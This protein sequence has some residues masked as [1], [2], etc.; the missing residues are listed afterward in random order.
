MERSRQ[1]CR[2]YKLYRFA[3][4]QDPDWTKKPAKELSFGAVGKR[5]LYTRLDP[6]DSFDEITNQRLRR[7]LWRFQPEP[8]PDA[9]EVKKRGR[10]KK[11]N[12]DAAKERENDVQKVTILSDLRKNEL[13]NLLS[14]QTQRS[15]RCS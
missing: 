6:L 1:I 12:D 2:S 3:K 5:W 9:K 8:L 10:P 7:S 13:T 4:E 11:S 15:S 14:T